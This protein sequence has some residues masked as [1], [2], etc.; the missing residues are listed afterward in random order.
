MNLINVPLQIFLARLRAG[1]HYGP[2]S[3]TMEVGLFQWSEFMV[4][5]LWFNS[6][7]KIN[8]KS[9]GS[10]TR[11]KSN[12]DQEEWPCTKKWMCWFFYNKYIPKKG[13]FEKNSSLINL[14][15]SLGLYLSWHLVIC[16]E[17]V[18]CKFSH[19]NIYKK[20]E[21]LNLYKLNVIYMWHVP[22]VVHWALFAK[23]FTMCT[24]ILEFYMSDIVWWN[25]WE[26][27]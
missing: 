5:L 16:V 9:L 26:Q 25:M 10:L 23:C 6:L 14:L 21:R 24:Q 13:I 3:R 2:W 12:L 8:F 7:K 1:L 19:N 11:C 15:S 17:D 27:V 20:N 4:Q 18:A 22:C